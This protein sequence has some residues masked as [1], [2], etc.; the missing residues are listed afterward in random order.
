[1]G[2]LESQTKGRQ[3]IFVEHVEQIQGTDGKG[4]GLVSVNPARLQKQCFCNLVFLKCFEHR[5]LLKITFSSLPFNIKSLIVQPI[6]PKC[7]ELSLK[8]V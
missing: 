8:P 7:T 2:P 6:S 1:M 4:A 5:G 3:W